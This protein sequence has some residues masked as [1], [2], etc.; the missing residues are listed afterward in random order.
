MT[1]LL[2]A[3]VPR[4]VRTFFPEHDVRTA[5]EMG[6]GELKNGALLA[7]AEPQ[8]E[9]LVTCDKNL[10][11]QQNLESRKIAILVLPSND[12]PFLKEKASQVRRA[13]AAIAPGEFVELTLF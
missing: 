1:I 11:Y 2:D 6:W 7:V 4:P 9:L 10:S 5:Q 13:I 12:W 8:F 3:C